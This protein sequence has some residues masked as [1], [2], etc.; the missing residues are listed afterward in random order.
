[1]KVCISVKG[2]FWAF[3]LAREL[4]TIG[5]HVRLI[6]SYPS[7]VAERFGVSREKVD[8]LLGHEV[9][10]RLWT[11][12]IPD[13]VRLPLERRFSIQEWLHDLFDWRVSKMLRGDTDIFVGWASLSLRSLRQ[14][15][16]LGAKTIVERGS[17]HV[18]FQ[19]DILNEEHELAGSR[20][21]RRPQFAVERD[22][23]EY[24]EADYIAIPS[25]FVRR[26]FLK[27]GIPESK[28]IQVP[29]GVDLT[30][31]S[32]IGKAD[33]IFRVIHCGQLS[34]RKGV[35]YL[36]RAFH[37][38]KL[39]NSELW[40]IGSLTEEIRPFLNRFA[41]QNIRLMGSFPQ[42]QLS[43]YYSQGSVFCLAS[44][45]E[46]L[47]MVQPQA[48]AC[49]LPVICTT[50]TGGEDIVTPGREGF[51]VPIRS[52]E[53]LKERIQQL[54]EDPGLTQRMGEAARQRA[55]KYLSWGKYGMQMHKQY[56]RILGVDK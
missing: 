31:F 27:Y 23:R 5:D 12:R 13:S 35:H 37:E 40:L 43:K 1:M 3:D 8:S 34:I 14:A 53:A 41:S 33:G 19:E 21:L 45:E 36:L 15:K 29:F 39:P 9:V 17:S 55:L 4:L 26:T 6:T 20:Y 51:I 2:R 47:A 25:T 49:G 50:N 48:M 42:N 32:P 56:L 18:Q 16:S 44:I 11:R 30:S 38:L 24:E 54:Y 52:V 7:Y 46:G 22:L 10:D 28:L